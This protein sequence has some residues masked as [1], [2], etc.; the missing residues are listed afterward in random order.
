MSCK[1]YERAIGKGDSAM[2]SIR[3]HSPEQGSC[4][5]KRWKIPTVL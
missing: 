4:W 2:A 3:K 5:A 1:C